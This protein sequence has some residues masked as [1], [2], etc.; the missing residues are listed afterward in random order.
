[1]KFWNAS[2]H[3]DYQKCQFHVITSLDRRGTSS[4]HVLEFSIIYP[5]VIA[6]FAENGAPRNFDT[7]LTEY[8][9]LHELSSS[10]KELQK[11]YS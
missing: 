3:L 6:Y 11:V 5:W 9:E 10:V 8:L 7:S 1:M 2:V 4:E